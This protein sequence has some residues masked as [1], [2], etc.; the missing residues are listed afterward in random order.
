MG[1][2]CPVQPAFEPAYALSSEHTLS[3]ITFEGLAAAADR[4]EVL[5]F[6]L[7]MGLLRLN[8]T[9]P[10]AIHSQVVVVGRG[11]LEDRYGLRVLALA[12]RSKRV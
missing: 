6:S 12:K 11:I 9:S 1:R 5:L 4:D 7:A 2:T 8:W 3:R 10:L